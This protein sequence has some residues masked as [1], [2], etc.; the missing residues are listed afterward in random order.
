MSYNN[1][2]FLY[3][4]RDFAVN[5]IKSLRIHGIKASICKGY[6]ESLD[7]FNQWIDIPTWIIH[8]KNTYLQVLLWLDFKRKYSYRLKYGV[9]SI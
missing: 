4:N 7:D 8:T 9:D 2:Y 3:Y 1:H 6:Q 5:H